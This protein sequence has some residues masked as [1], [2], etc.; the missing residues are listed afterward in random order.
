MRPTPIDLL[1]KIGNKSTGQ[2]QV[3]MSKPEKSPSIAVQKTARE[4]EV[5]KKI[6]KI[7]DPIRTRVVNWS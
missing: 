1:E 7:F 2:I 4:K 6:A 3:S 5:I